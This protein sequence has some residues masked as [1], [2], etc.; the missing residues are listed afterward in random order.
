MIPF[1]VHT[2]SFNSLFSLHSMRA[3]ILNYFVKFSCHSHSMRDLSAC[4]AF[5]LSLQ[6]SLPTII[7]LN[8]CMCGKQLLIL[9]ITFAGGETH[10]HN[11]SGAHKEPLNLINVANNLPQVIIGITN[12]G[13]TRAPITVWSQTQQ[14]LLM[15]ARWWPRRKKRRC[16]CAPRAD[17]AT[18]GRFQPQLLN[19][20][21]VN[22]DGNE[23]RALSNG[24]MMLN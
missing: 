3:S 7:E 1:Y 12:C 8:W 13:A 16:R 18:R 21:F 20:R 19:G 9:I 2:F 14:K 24:C 17:W 23:P 10:I 6:V 11:S 4:A 15:R 22:A 5:T